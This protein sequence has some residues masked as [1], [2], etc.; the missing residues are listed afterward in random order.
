MDLFRV[1][2]MTLYRSISNYYV[3]VHLALQ[4]KTYLKYKCIFG[5]TLVLQDFLKPLQSRVPL[6]LSFSVL[7]KMP[8]NILMVY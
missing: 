1:K 4:C 7:K 6:N 5:K 8:C 3:C 2:K